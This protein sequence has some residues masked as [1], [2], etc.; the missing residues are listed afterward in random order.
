MATQ[1]LV[2]IFLVALQQPVAVCLLAVCMCVSVCVLVSLCQA[3]SC[4]QS[5]GHSMHERWGM[6][7]QRIRGERLSHLR[8]PLVF[9]GERVNKREGE[10]DVSHRET[11]SKS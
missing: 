1:S 6:Q 10:E 5:V 11:K 8:S 2:Q 7:D 9:R 4:I 3:N